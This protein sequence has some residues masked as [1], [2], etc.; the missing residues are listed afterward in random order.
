MKRMGEKI[1]HSFIAAKETWGHHYI[2][3]MKC[4]SIK[5]HGKIHLHEGGIKTEDSAGNSWLVFQNKNGVIQVDFLQPG[6][7]TSSECCTVT[8]KPLKQLISGIWKDNISLEHDNTYFM[9]NIKGYCKVESHHYI[10]FFIQSTLG[11][12]QFQPFSKLKEYL[13]GHLTQIKR[14][15]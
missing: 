12:M 7:A 15:K 2:A 3:E 14:W 6:T 10:S 5:Y 9:G 4:Q 1:L 13:C 8:L 11:T